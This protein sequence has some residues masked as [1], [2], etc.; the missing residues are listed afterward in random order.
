MKV[1]T[2]YLI[3]GAIGLL[4]VLAGLAFWIWGGGSADPTKPTQTAANGECVAKETYEVTA[5]DYVLGKADAPL[6]IIEYASMTCIHCARFSREVYPTLKADYIDKGYVRYVFREFPLDEVA[7]TASVVGR[8]LARDQYLSYVELMYHELENW[9][10]PAD[11]NLRGSIKEMARR[12]GMSGD[13][14]EKCLSTEEDA[15]KVVE[16]R[17]KA[18]ADYCISGTPYF[19]LDGKKLAS[20]EIPWSELDDKLRAALKAKGVDVPAKAPAE[21]APAPTE[22]AAPADGA[23]PAEGTAPVAPA[24][25]TTPPAEGA[26]TPPAATPPATTPPA[27]TPAPASGTPTP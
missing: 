23:A 17:T 18:N 4:A 5:N 16:I 9:A 10:Q 6:T 1:D 14:F 15:K 12:A 7:L 2:P 25:G 26:A 11:N 22:G 27:T 20:G 3:A 8:C 13:D 24:D 19:L 21:G